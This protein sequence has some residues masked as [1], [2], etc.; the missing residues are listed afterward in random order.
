MTIPYLIHQ[1]WKTD[2]VPDHWKSSYERWNQV[3]DFT[4]KLW[5]D[6]MNRQLIADHYSWFLE[7]YDS[8]AYNI[9]RAD[10]ARYFI[11]H[12]YGGIY[13]DLDIAPIVTTMRALVDFYNAQG[14]N[15]VIGKSALSFGTNHGLTNAFMM[16]CEGSDFWPVVWRFLEY[17]LRNAKTRTMKRILT[18]STKHFNIIF[19]TGPGIINEAAQQ[20]DLEYP[21]SLFRIPSEFV[22][23]SLEWQPKPYRTRDSAVEILDGGSW[24]SWDSKCFGVLHRLWYN[25]TTVLIIV[26]IAILL[27]LLIWKYTAK[28]RN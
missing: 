14:A 11:L 18:R 8:Y 9:Q 13:C 2:T 17:P 10:A 4:Y 25:H 1:T 20:Y 27:Y 28:Y 6:E 7:K 15:I 21:D 16:S 5:T 22:Q 12:R 23:P 24:H 26:V 3:P 19:G